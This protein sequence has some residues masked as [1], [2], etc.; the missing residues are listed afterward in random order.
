LAEPLRQ[1][2]GWR[3]ERLD[4][5]IETIAR[6]RD[7]LHVDLAER[8]GPTFASNPDRLFAADE[9]HPSSEGHGVWAAAVLDAIGDSEVA[10]SLG[11]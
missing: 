7:L 4:E 3:G 1:I 11:S 8:T 9:Y 10:G 2:A 6:N 5:E